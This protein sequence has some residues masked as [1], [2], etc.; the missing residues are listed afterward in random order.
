MIW[1]EGLLSNGQRLP[2]GLLPL[3]VPPGGGERVPDIYHPV[4]DVVVLRPLCG[5][6]DGDH[7]TIVL[8]GL[9]I[10]AEGIE[11]VAEVAVGPSDIR[12]CLTKGLFANANQTAAAK[13]SLPIFA[14]RMERVAEPR[15]FPSDVGVIGA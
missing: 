11:R 4:P 12:V 13:F 1:S 10:L 6:H 8:D 3:A 15:Q 9:V 2:Q 7:A 5:L 14:G